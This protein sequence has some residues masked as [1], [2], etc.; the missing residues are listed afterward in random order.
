MKGLKTTSIGS[1][2]GKSNGSN[3]LFLDFI[4]D[5]NDIIVFSN[6]S[7]QNLNKLCFACNN[8]YFNF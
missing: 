1:D 7:Q 5:D 3:L 2:D 6:T 8:I 4:D